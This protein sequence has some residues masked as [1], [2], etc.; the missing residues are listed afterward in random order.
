M[1]GGAASIMDTI[2]AGAT[3]AIEFSGSC[4]TSMLGNEVY[5][6]IFGAGFV[7]IGLMLV[8]RLRSTAQF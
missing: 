5:A 3:K 6:F 7:G 4:L 1:E 8:S 2:I